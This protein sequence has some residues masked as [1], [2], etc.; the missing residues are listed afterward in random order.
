MW[1]IDELI[2]GENHVRAKGERV[3]QSKKV[4]TRKGRRVG[5]KGFFLVPFK[6]SQR[7][8]SESFGAELFNCWKFFGSCLILKDEVLSRGMIQVQKIETLIKSVQKS[9]VPYPNFNAANHTPALKSEENKGAR[10][11]IATI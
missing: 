6:A 3:G 5:V 11:P 10:E 4:W 9:S 8:G 1:C 7:K 2:A